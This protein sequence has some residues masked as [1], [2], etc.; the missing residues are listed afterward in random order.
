MSYGDTTERRDVASNKS[1]RRLLARPRK[2]EPKPLR[3]RIPACLP[4]RVALHPRQNR[5]RR[6]ERFS[7][8]LPH[9]HG[10]T[11]QC[12][13]KLVH[14]STLHTSE[15]TLRSSLMTRLIPASRILPAL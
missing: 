5:R 10:G 4:G 11:I 3:V 2:S 6:K 8:V 9:P 13:C 15:S 7:K 1:R 14:S 12:F